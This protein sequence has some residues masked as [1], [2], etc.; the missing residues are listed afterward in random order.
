ML[1]SY[2]GETRWFLSRHATRK[3]ALHANT[4]PGPYQGAS[5]SLYENRGSPL[6]LTISLSLS[7]YFFLCF[8]KSPSLMVVE[9]L[10]FFLSFPQVPRRLSLSLSLYFLFCCLKLSCKLSNSFLSLPFSKNKFSELSL[11]CSLR[12]EV[13]PFDFCPL[14]ASP[15]CIFISE[16]GSSP[17]PLSFHLTFL[18]PNFFNYPIFHLTLPLSSSFYF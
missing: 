11:A 17:L 3:L 8:S 12:T 5:V 14:L 2:C 15:L 6:P 10:K 7:I 16:N 13:L 18:T 4:R 9:I 1:R